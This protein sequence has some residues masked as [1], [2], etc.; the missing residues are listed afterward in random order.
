MKKNHLYIFIIALLTILLITCRK[1]SKPVKI[2]KIKRDTITSIQH[3]TIY[4]TLA[5][6]IYITDPTVITR[7]VPIP[8]DTNLYYARTYSDTIAS[9]LGIDVHYQAHVRGYLD[10]ITLGYLGDLPVRTTKEFVTITETKYIDPSGLYVSGAFHT[11]TGPGAGLSYLKKRWQ[12]GY[13]YYPADKSHQASIAF[14]I[15]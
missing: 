15:R 3:D 5:D 14:K 7:E 2:L 6:T 10:N 9:R 11:S 13:T 4:I 12:V 1:E 8:A